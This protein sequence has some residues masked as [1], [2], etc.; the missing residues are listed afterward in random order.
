MRY[1]PATHRRVTPSHSELNPFTIRT[2][3]PE[4]LA[5]T[6]GSRV[7]AF[8][9]A[10]DTAK[11]AAVPPTTR[12]RTPASPTTTNGRRR[13]CGAPPAR[14]STN[15]SQH[16]AFATPTKAAITTWAGPGTWTSTA[17]APVITMNVTNT[18]RTV[19]QV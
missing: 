13:G 3:G 14:A 15:R 11:P 16:Q 2:G 12:T 18:T 9:T 8:S 4:A 10:T 19:S 5:A 1:R 17:P 7:R 6:G